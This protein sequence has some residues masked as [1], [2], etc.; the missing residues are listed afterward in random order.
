MKSKI[1]LS[2]YQSAVVYVQIGGQ[3]DISPDDDRGSVCTEGAMCAQTLATNQKHDWGEFRM[4]CVLIPFTLIHIEHAFIL[5]LHE[6]WTVLQST[7]FDI[8]F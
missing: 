7:Q 3:P 5:L 2:A 1:Q 8:V 4:P 6:H